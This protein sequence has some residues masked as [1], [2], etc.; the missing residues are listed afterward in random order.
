V[1]RV[2]AAVGTADYRG[3]FRAAATLRGP[4]DRFF[5]EVFVM[6]EDERV[7]QARLRLMAEL[8]DLV[9]G[10]ADISELVWSTET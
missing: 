3:A 10:L 4:I 7:R 9:L 2:R 1:P 8:R 5:T 6:V